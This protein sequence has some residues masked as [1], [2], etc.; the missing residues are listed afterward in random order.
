MGKLTENKKVIEDNIKKAEF[1]F[2]MDLSENSYIKNGDRSGDD[3][4]PGKYA[5]RRERH[6]AEKL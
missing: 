5:E 3:E 2:A 1:N 4:S 6:G